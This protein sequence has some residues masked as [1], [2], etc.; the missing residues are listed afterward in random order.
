M[1][2]NEASAAKIFLSHHGFVKGLA[3]R[4]APLPG[5]A[6]DIVQQVFVEFL[7]K[8]DQ[9]DLNSDIAPL[10]ATM[11]RHVALRYWREQTR[12]LPEVMQKLAE[13]VRRIAEEQSV[14]PRYEEELSA[15]RGCL[16]R[17]PDK[18]RMLIDLYYYASVPTHAIA[19]Q[20]S[21]KA[22]TVRRA[23]FRLRERL[24]ECIEKSLA[25]GVAD[26]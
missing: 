4:H 21:M 26:A 9:W 15:L 6:D 10:L 14:P 22:D 13:H 24:R 3:L 7:A 25:G 20:M 17:L 19:S 23:L 18:S 2:P 1:L 5:L 16:D 11:T 8:A 12:K